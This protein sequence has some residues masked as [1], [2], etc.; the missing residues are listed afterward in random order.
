MW[1]I[2]DLSKLSVASRQEKSLVLSPSKAEM[3]SSSGE[4]VTTVHLPTLISLAA[5]RPTIPS[6]ISSLSASATFKGSPWVLAYCF[7]WGWKDTDW[8]YNWPE[9][10]KTLHGQSLARWSRRLSWKTIFKRHSW[11]SC[12]VRSHDLRPKVT[13]TQ[14]KSSHPPHFLISCF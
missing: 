6:S 11:C 8:S 10:L 1:P 9:R 13:Q 7:C 12:A 14:L 3:P 4:T 2:R 5:A